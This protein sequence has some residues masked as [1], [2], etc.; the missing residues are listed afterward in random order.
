MSCHLIGH[1]AGTYHGLST[2]PEAGQPAQVVVTVQMRQVRPGA[3]FVTGVLWC[4]HGEAGE[5]RAAEVRR[6]LVRDARV[7]LA[8]QAVTYCARS[9]NL[10]VRGLE[11]V[12]VVAPNGCVLR[13]ESLRP[14][15]PEPTTTP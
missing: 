9:N 3:P 7:S 13:F 2:G 5:S 12:N 8:G 1:V 15:T 4:G 11:A 10:N 14:T 6:E